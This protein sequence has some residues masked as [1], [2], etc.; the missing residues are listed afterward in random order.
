MEK[1]WPQVRR[2]GSATG[3][4]WTS[5]LSFICQVVPVIP[6]G[7]QEAR[8]RRERKV[9]GADG[10]SSSCYYLGGGGQPSVVEGWEPRR[11][12]NSI[13]GLCRA[14]SILWSNCPSAASIL[15]NHQPAFPPSSLM[16]VT[17]AS[18]APTP[19]QT[20]PPS[21]RKHLS[22]QTCPPEAF[23]IRPP[24]SLLIPS[25]PDHSSQMIPLGCAPPGTHSHLIMVQSLA[26]EK[27]ARSSGVTTRHV[28]DSQAP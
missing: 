6:K 10:A 18:Q 20:L 19:G 12:R 28:I 1:S 5:H 13:P 14:S 16:T 4:P 22:E 25:S 9:L 2:P 7:S 15:L 27:M 24:S 3:S 23:P 26:A 17:G 8:K 11:T 21:P